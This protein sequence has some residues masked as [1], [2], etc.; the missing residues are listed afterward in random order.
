MLA[1]KNIVQYIKYQISKDSKRHLKNEEAKAIP[2]CSGAG[3]PGLLGC[4]P[5]QG[6]GNNLHGQVQVVPQVLDTC[7]KGDKMSKLNTSFTSVAD[8]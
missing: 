7:S 3:G 4:L 5:L 2:G 8:P 1:Y 6:G